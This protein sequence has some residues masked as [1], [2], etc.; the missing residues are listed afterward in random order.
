MANNN[1]L[2]DIIEAD[3]DARINQIYAGLLLLGAAII[4]FKFMSAI[5]SLVSKTP[6]NMEGMK[7]WVTKTLHFNLERHKE[8][9]VQS[10]AKRAGDGNRT[11]SSFKNIR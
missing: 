6:Q 3:F 2:N 7:K 9:R 10:P 5:S 4:Q 1:I 11:C 8:E